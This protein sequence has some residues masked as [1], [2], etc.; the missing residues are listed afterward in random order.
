MKKSLIALA[1][2]AAVGA[3]SAQSS[4][5]LYGIMDAG[6]TR[7]SGGLAG[8]SGVTRLDSGIASGTRFGLRGTEDLG[9]GLKANFVAE[10]GFCGDS[11]VNANS[12]GAATPNANQNGG[13]APGFCT[14][15]NAFMGRQ[16]FVGVEGGFGRVDLGRQLTPAFLLL[17][18]LDPFQTG[19][20]GQITNLFDS[21]GGYAAAG[22]NSANPRMNNT[23]KYS[24]ANLSGFTAQVAYGL[25]ENAGNSTLSRNVGFHAAY[26]NGPIY[27]G[28]GYHDAKSNALVGGVQDG[29]KNVLFGATY[30]FEVAKAHFA[31]GTT[32]NVVAQA[33][34]T[35]AQ[36]ANP[37]AT[38]F[39]NGDGRNMMIGVSAPVG[40]GSLRASYLRHDDKGVNNFDSNQVGVGYF[41]SLSK[42]TTLYTAY[43]KISAKNGAFQTVGNAGNG[44]IGN[45]A[46]NVGA[47]HSF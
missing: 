7:D 31:Y 34:F 42:R 17:G 37:G 30:D 11:N 16:A 41:Y 43:A 27:A 29:R 23:V 6:I 15:G 8:A 36:I 10:T 38:S 2:F 39:N 24:S 33:A 45:S 20:A 5:T 28:V 47:R 32:K 3:A 26:S 1:A 44:G 25:G 9:G 19:T 40:P 21:A 4:V 18:A 35:P 46:F 13:N 14:G 12:G 22:A